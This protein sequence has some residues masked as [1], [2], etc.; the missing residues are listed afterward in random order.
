[1][2][3][4]E[5]PAG[6]TIPTPPNQPVQSALDVEIYN[7]ATHGENDKAPAKKNSLLCRSRLDFV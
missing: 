7:T 5:K 1:V 2:L 6:L 3:S 4:A